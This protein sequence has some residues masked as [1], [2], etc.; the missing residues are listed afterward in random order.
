[1]VCKFKGILYLRYVKV[2]AFKKGTNIYKGQRAL[3]YVSKKGY[4][5]LSEQNSIMACP[6]KMVLIFLCFRLWS[7]VAKWDVNCISQT[8]HL[9]DTGLY[10][11]QEDIV[12][13]WAL[14]HNMWGHS[15]DDNNLS[16][17]SYTQR[18]VQPDQC[19]FTVQITCSNFKYSL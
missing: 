2:N 19:Y 1:M 3:I 7:S 11:L 6:M 12:L 4:L 14:R 9:S 18:R 16:L 15:D 8:E 17:Y 10:V 5:N 13:M